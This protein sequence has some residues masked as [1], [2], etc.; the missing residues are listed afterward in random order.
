MKSSLIKT[1]LGT[2]KLMGKSHVPPT[3][4]VLA[5]SIMSSN[6]PSAFQNSATLNSALTASH[7]NAKKQAVP[8]HLTWKP[9]LDWYSKP[10]SVLAS[11]AA[12]QTKAQH[13]TSAW[14]D[15]LAV[16]LT[17]SIS[18]QRD[19]YKSND[20]EHS[21]KHTEPVVSVASNDSEENIMSQQKSEQNKQ[22]ELKNKIEDYI[23][24]HQS[25]GYAESLI[26][27]LKG[28]TNKD[29]NDAA[30]ALKKYLL[31]DEALNVIDLDGAKKIA[32]FD[33]DLSHLNEEVISFKMSKLSGKLVSGGEDPRLMALQRELQTLKTAQNN[34]AVDRVSA[35][36]QTLTQSLQVG[37]LDERV[38]SL[39][40]SLDDVVS[41]L[42]LKDTELKQINKALDTAQTDLTKAQ[43]ESTYLRGEVE[44]ISK[45]HE[46][47]VDG[48]KEGIKKAIEAGADNVEVLQKVLEEKQR[49][50]AIQVLGLTGKLEQAEFKG[51]RLAHQV[52]ELNIELT[53][54]RQ[55][56]FNL[57]ENL[58][59][60]RKRNGQLKDESSSLKNLNDQ[61]KT[62][63]AK[64]E[65]E[66]S[67]AILLA[68]KRSVKLE[69]ALRSAY[70]SVKDLGR[71]LDMVKNERDEFRAQVGTLEERVKYLGDSL[72]DVV[73]Q[74]NLKDT[75]LKQINKALDT[76]QTDLT[77]AQ[78]ESTY[79]RGE[80]EAISKTH[81]LEVD[82]LKEGIKKAIEAGADNVE[83]LQKVLEEKQR[84]Y[85]IQVLGLTGKLEQAEFK[86]NRLAHQVVEL[87][88]EL[89]QGRQEIFNLKEN[90]TELRKRNGQLK[91]ESSSL[92]NLND[93]Q[94]T[95]FAKKEQE[96]SGAIVLAEKRSV[97]LENALHSAY[98]SVK[99]LGRNLDIVKN[100]RDEFR[101]QV[102][103]L[104]QKNDKLKE[105]MQQLVSDGIEKA[106]KI[107]L[108][109]NTL[110]LKKL[111]YEEMIAL[112]NSE[113]S[114]LA[115]G[116]N[117]VANAS[118]IEE[119]INLKNEVYQLKSVNT[120]LASP[121][122]V[123]STSVSRG[124]SELIS[125]QHNGQLQQQI[126]AIKLENNSLR[127]TVHT[128]L[129][130]I[131]K[132]VVNNPHPEMLQ[133]AQDN[134]ARLTQLLA[135]AQNENH[136]LKESKLGGPLNSPR[137]SRSTAPTSLLLD[138][139]AAVPITG[140]VTYSPYDR[141]PRVKGAEVTMAM[142]SDLID[143]EKIANLESQLPALA[144]QVNQQVPQQ[145]KSNPNTNALDFTQAQ[146]GAILN[147][148]AAMSNEIAALKTE[149]LQQ[150]QVNSTT[151]AASQRPVA[152]SAAAATAN[153]S[154][155]YN[156]PPIQ[157]R[158]PVTA[159][160]TTSPHPTNDKWHRFYAEH[161]LEG[162]AQAD[163]SRYTNEVLFRKKSTVA[164]GQG[165]LVAVNLSQK[166]IED[167]NLFAKFQKEA[168]PV[169]CPTSGQEYLLSFKGEIPSA[170]L[171]E[172]NAERFEG[173]SDDEHLQR[174]A[175]TIINMLDNV[176]AKSEE[177]NIKTS[178]PF[179]AEI[180][181]SYL[182]Y[183][184]TIKDA[185]GY[186]FKIDVKLA[187]I[188][189]SSDAASQNQNQKAKEIFAKLKEYMPADE[190][191]EA[192][193][194]KDAVEF[195]NENKPSIFSINQ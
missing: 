88:I 186:P 91:D 119:L 82:G 4:G 145:L 62:A 12:P 28:F 56:I 140:N 183:L 75:E 148:M 138:Q 194:F 66:L 133:L 113:K 118:M 93:Q 117:Q 52:V 89:T 187:S 141:L 50:Y 90:L 192:Q 124:Q 54:G 159:S 172:K 144:T 42:N 92:K 123:S 150:R 53:Q 63:F 40:R 24:S 46:L 163:N 170:V 30:A 104:E 55:E 41:Q 29:K 33:G 109:E 87:N 162:D 143:A 114:Q 127:E 190:I 122:S 57:K 98:S 8:P 7:F 68:E 85:A 179:L 31:D 193:W 182:T 195:R 151:A 106:N 27:W 191:R 174:R 84:D 184:Q 45:T 169:I 99:D 142:R 20:L 173:D 101:A 35:D 164:T 120:G 139:N 44:A 188:V 97:K 154:Q 60:L 1:A 43:G 65:Q 180:A 38:E 110:E 71:N 166:Q 47:E 175:A 34:A 153:T 112:L 125:D 107:A 105:G 160:S 155:H 80:V 2:A 11:K 165:I 178:D 39:A 128:L 70:S 111:H 14:I 17:G 135:A 149:V 94:K 23:T 181:S 37:T 129:A 16:N 171:K 176:L 134:I 81:E 100:E 3:L 69:N 83:V 25:V 156:S 146:M 21:T 121:S 73:S 96:L 130:E 108:L 10:T 152:G 161:K 136:L 26:N 51:N 64:K 48:L 5:T 102:S 158:A 49:D 58:T 9:S 147:S 116:F 157:P 131:K 86:G 137:S 95:A 18:L 79:L 132:P 126:D 189:A 59:E 72:G 15:Q 77:K 167:P 36:Q 32:L 168:V 76:A 13:P 61:Q 185:D 22:T 67:G 103:I 78:G 74:L 6:S 19:L 115:L 177:I